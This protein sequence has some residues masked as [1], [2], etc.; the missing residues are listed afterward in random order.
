MT[1]I[2]NI[3]LQDIINHCLEDKLSQS[4][5]SAAE[6][7]VAVAKAVS[8]EILTRHADATDEAI[9]LLQERINNTLVDTS[10]F[11]SFM[12]EVNS[13][14]TD[15]EGGNVVLSLME[16]TVAANALT[17]QL[18]QDLEDVDLELSRLTEISAEH[19]ERITVLEPI[20]RSLP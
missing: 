11:V 5:D 14:L 9:K 19:G 4:F 16:D 17:A 6:L 20:V 12:E 7:S 15:E 18:T 8:E 2:T 13:V 1:D 3:D 10:A